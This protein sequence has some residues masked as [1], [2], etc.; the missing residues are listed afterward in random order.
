MGHVEVDVR[1]GSSEAKSLTVKALVDT[2]ATFTVI[3]TGI[4]RELNL[5]PTGEKVKVTTAKGIDTLDLTHATLELD[6][7]RRIMPV[8]ISDHIDRVLL[9]VIALE[10]ME[11]RVNPMTGKLEESSALLFSALSASNR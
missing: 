2:G 3:P 6:S 5:Q 1:I 9:G 10:A 8:L 11:M 7:K 4:A